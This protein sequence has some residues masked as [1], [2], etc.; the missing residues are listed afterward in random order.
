MADTITDQRAKSHS[1]GPVC[2]DLTYGFA[3]PVQGCLGDQ[4]GTDRRG[5]EKKNG[6]QQFTDGTFLTL[7][8]EKKNSSEEYPSNPEGGRLGRAVQ[9]GKNIRETHQ[10]DGADERNA[11]TEKDQ[12][13]ADNFQNHLRLPLLDDVAAQKKLGQ[14][15]GAYE[16][17]QGNEDGGLVEE[18]LTVYGT[19]QDQ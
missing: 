6:N 2:E 17:E 11:G 1:V 8:D 5:Q 3:L 10:P 15:N 19:G 16:A 18:L 12:C 9:P 13:R 14:R 7:E 4:V